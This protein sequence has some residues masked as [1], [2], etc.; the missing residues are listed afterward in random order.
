MCDRGDLAEHCRTVAMG[1]HIVGGSVGV[2]GTP[3]ACSVHS[4]EGP[5]N[6]S[7]HAKKLLHRLETCV[8]FQ[9]VE[10]YARTRTTKA[11]PPRLLSASAARQM[12]PEGF[13]PSSQNSSLTASTRLFAVLNLGD[14]STGN[15]VRIAQRQYFS[16]IAADAP[17]TDQPDEFDIK[18]GFLRAGCP[19]LTAVL[20]RQ[21]DG[22]GHTRSGQQHRCWQLLFARFLTRPT[23]ASA[24]H[25]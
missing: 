4:Q 23:S 18:R 20:F 12:E 5:P 16:P 9:K 17:A 11:A 19:R 22:P 25:G 3:M 13:E 21:P 1:F 15:Y 10:K 14:L 6:A 8:F 7:F 2:C 24:C